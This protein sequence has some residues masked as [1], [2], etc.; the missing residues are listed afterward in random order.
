MQVDVGEL[1]KEAAEYHRKL[2]ITTIL[3]TFP[4]PSASFLSSSMIHRVNFLEMIGDARPLVL[5]HQSKEP[6]P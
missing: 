5:T 1:R 4:L 3:D 6:F 2:F